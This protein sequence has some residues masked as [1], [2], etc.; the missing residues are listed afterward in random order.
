MLLKPSQLN[1]KSIPQLQAI[2]T[3][4]FNHFIRLRDS[5]LPCISCGGF[6]KLEAGHYWP[7]THHGTKWHE[8]NVNG[9]CKSCN[10][11]G[12]G[13]MAGYGR[14][15]VRRYGEGIMLELEIAKN[16]HPHFTRFDL[17]QMIEH[18]KLKAKEVEHGIASGGGSF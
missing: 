18:Y 15:L 2:L 1:R 13:N 7:S 9:Q 6:R 10:E 11:F 5:G 4:H 8:R 3:R 12:H 14:G 17:E 16:R